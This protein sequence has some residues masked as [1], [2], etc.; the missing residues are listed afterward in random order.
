MYDLNILGS[1]K[2]FKASMQVDNTAIE[3]PQK[4]V[5]RVVILMFTDVA[6]PA[7]LGFGTSLPSQETYNISDLSGIRNDYNIAL[8]AVRDQIQAT[9]PADAPADEQM[10]DFSV[11]I[12]ES[13][14]QGQVNADITITTEAGTGVAISLPV[15]TITE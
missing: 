13:D 1:P 11:E 9:T 14:E 2:S 6:E 3:G 15:D 5:Q 4:L 7:N 10:V 8:S 12:T